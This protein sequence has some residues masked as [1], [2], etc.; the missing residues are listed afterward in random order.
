MLHAREGGAAMKDSKPVVATS[1][2]EVMNSVTASDDNYKQQA[3][4]IMHIT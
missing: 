1:L 4:S 3:N 2:L